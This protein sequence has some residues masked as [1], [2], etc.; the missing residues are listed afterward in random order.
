LLDGAGTKSQVKERYWVSFAPG[1]IRTCAVCHGINTNNQA[2]VAG[3]PQ[4][5]SQALRTLLQF[6]K[7]NNPPGTM[8]HSIAAVVSRKDSGVATLSVTRIAGSVG[9]VSVNYATANG[10]AVAGADYT[11]TSGT[12]TWSDGDTAAKTITI[13]LLNNPTIAATKDFTVALSGPVNG[14]IGATATATLTLQ[15]P[16]FQAWQFSNFGANANVP[17]IAGDGADP[18]GD[19]LANLLEYG[20]AGNPTAASSAPLPTVATEIVGGTKFLTL[21]YTHDVTRT[22]VSYHPQVSSDLS[23]GV[24]TDLTDAPISQTGNLETRKV[25]VPSTGAKE[26]LRVR[27]SRP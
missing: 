27:V 14:S 19:G 25:S 13:P 5:K 22:D 12:L 10:T 8:Q 17:A 26:F 16:P 2:N 18:D 4:N 21:T 1:E 23:A 11:A 9:P 24:W 20:L 3:L 7:G 6:W 15:E